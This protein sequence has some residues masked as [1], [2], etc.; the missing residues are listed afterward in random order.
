MAKYS[1]SK[2]EF[3]SDHS[4]TPCCANV[5]GKAGKSERS[6]TMAFSTAV[7]LSKWLCMAQVYLL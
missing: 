7:C 4:D 1:A 6:S 3:T 5:R 2:V